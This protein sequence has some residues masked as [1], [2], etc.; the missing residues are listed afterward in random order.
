MLGRK[1][2]FVTEQK[3]FVLLLVLHRSYSRW[4]DRLTPFDFQ[5]EHKPGAKIGLG[6]FLLRHP[7]SYAKPVSTYDSMFTVAKISIIRSAFGFQKKNFSKGK[8]ESPMANNNIRVCNISNREQSLENKKTRV[9]NWI[10]HRATNCISGRSS[11]F[12]D[13]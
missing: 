6:D 4:L 13:S 8:I 5:M 11:K 10:N 2:L 9:G 7:S 3:A 12:N 1:F